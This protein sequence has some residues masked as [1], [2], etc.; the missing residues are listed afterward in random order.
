MSGELRVESVELN[1]VWTLIKTR[2]IGAH[3]IAMSGRINDGFEEFRVSVD[4]VE[5]SRG[6][7]HD[8]KRE[9]RRWVRT[10]KHLCDSA[11]LR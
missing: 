4:C 5:Q 8:C 1:G 9:W 11:P 10:L 7:L 3:M 6:S 2:N